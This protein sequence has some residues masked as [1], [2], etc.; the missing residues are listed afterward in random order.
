MKGVVETPGFTFLDSMINPGEPI[1]ISD[2][3]GH[4]ALALGYITDIRHNRVTVQVDRRLHNARTRKPGFN[5]NTNQVFTGIM[6]VT[7]DGKGQP[8]SIYDDQD[9]ILYRLDKDEFSNGMS[10]IR[11]N[12]IQIM[13]PNAS[14]RYRRLLVDLEPPTFKVSPTA[15]TLD[16]SSQANLNGD[17]RKAIEKVMAG[18]LHL[19]SSTRG[20]R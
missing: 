19:L 5:K 13:S 2:E 15:Y 11:N 16:T 10:S 1:V 7:K 9:E 4:F 6:E 8:F 14:D 17:Q 18:K 20:F 12:L 3:Q